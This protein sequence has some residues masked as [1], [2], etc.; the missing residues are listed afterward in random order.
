MDT[1]LRAHRAPPDG[2]QPMCTGVG[3]VPLPA[4]RLSGTA[5]LCPSRCGA[6][7]RARPTGA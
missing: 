1:L 2:T 5:G 7:R 6:V 4:S 3:R